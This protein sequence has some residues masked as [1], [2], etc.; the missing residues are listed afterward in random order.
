MNK[1]SAIL[2]ELNEEYLRLHTEHER[3]YWVS[4]MGNK[5]KD[6]EFQQAKAALDKFRESREI[7]KRKVLDIL[8][9]E[10]DEQ[11]R[12]RL[13]NWKRFFETYQIPEWM[14][15]LRERI[16]ELET[17][18]QTKRAETK[19]SYIDPKTLERCEIPVNKFWL[20]IVT[21]EDEAMRKACFDWREETASKVV[22]DE[23]VELISMRNEYARKLGYR[24]FYHYKAQIEEQMDSDEIFRI[25]D[26]ICMK[27]TPFFKS[28][29]EGLKKSNPNICQPWNM[30]YGITW[31]FER[32]EDPYFPMETI[33]DTWGKTFA[34]LWIDYRGWLMRLDLLERHLKYNNWFCHQPITVHYKDS[35]RVPWEVNFT[36][37]AIIWQIGSWSM[38]S[39]TC[40]HE[41]WHAAHFF[42]MDNQDVCLNTEFPP[43]STA[44]AE[45]Q[46]MFLDTIMSSP[47]W[48]TR[49][50]RT[51]DW[52]SYPFDLFERKIRKTFILEPLHMLRMSSV[53]EFERR[54]YSEPNL[55]SEKVI[56]IAQETATKYN[57][58]ESPSTYILMTPHLY[59]WDASCS[60]HWYALATLALT[61]W[62]EAMYEKCW[63][64]VDNPAIWAEMR[65][66]WEF[67]SSKSFSE[68]IEIA[69]GKKLSPDAFINSIVNWEEHTINEA[70][71]RIEV[72]KSVPEYTGEPDLN[73][74]IFIVDGEQTL[75]T[76]EHWFN[77]M[78]VEFRKHIEGIKPKD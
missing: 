30:W 51:L 47:E 27:L 78:C 54:M 43:L 55:T 4:Y 48:S 41:G 65:K 2:D 62:R 76:N 28:R 29:L 61:Q 49:Y 58:Y 45:T 35:E 16:T 42:N 6:E 23:Y 59:S 60:Y 7:L 52:Q 24:D 57:Q 75:A 10:T 26:E 9:S 71:E 38:T 34:G 36:C 53:I 20:M 63:H 67:W 11:L 74:Q 22:V 66:V 3:H 39:R 70:K 13:L 44:W 64:I 69:T 18:I 68:M 17:R 15:D 56:Q 77:Q 25:F 32:K 31:D 50:A 73:A 5:D 21:E 37:N 1:T 19:Y 12:A 72:M 33:I 40:F 14:W 8:E 46:S